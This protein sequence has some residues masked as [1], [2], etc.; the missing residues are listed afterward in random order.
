[1]GKAGQAKRLKWDVSSCRPKGWWH[2]W[3]ADIQGGSSKWGLRTD[4]RW[5]P[6]LQLPSTMKV[7]SSLLNVWF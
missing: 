4:P 2:F 7:G 1:M 3:I 5:A 6:N